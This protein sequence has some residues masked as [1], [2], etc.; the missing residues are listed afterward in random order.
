MCLGTLLR[1]CYGTRKYEKKE[2]EK[3]RRA[4]GSFMSFH[5]LKMRT[6]SSYTTCSLG[7]EAPRGNHMQGLQ[8]SQKFSLGLPHEFRVVARNTEEDVTCLD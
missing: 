4:G 5:E 2:K 7:F 6:F 1:Q 3:E 8:R